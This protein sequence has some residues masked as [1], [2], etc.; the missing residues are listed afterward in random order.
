MV[1]HSCCHTGN[2]AGPAVLPAS[3]GWGCWRAWASLQKKVGYITPCAAALCACPAAAG[4]F[5]VGND[6]VHQVGEGQHQGDGE[7]Q[8]GHQGDEHGQGQGGQGEELAED[9]TDATKA[10]SSTPNKAPRRPFKR[11][12][13]FKQHDKAG[14]AGEHH[15]QGGHVLVGEPQ[16]PLRAHSS[17][18]LAVMVKAAGN[19]LP[20]DV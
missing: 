4:G 18:M 5:G 2:S 17:T 14:Q 15:R 12:A 13:D 7:Q 10:A 6:V 19:A 16:G 20:D 9:S 8:D 1:R 11:C 3:R